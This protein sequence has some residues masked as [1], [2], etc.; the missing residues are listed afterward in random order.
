MR[1]TVYESCMH[2]FHQTIASETLYDVRFKEVCCC[3]PSSRPPARPLESFCLKD[4]CCVTVFVTV[5]NCFLFFRTQGL[6]V[7]SFVV[8]MVLRMIRG[9]VS[10]TA[11]FNVRDLCPIAHADRTF[12]PALFVAGRNDDFIRPHHSQQIHD[13]YAGDKNIVLVEGDHNSSRPSF[14]FDSV[15]IFLQNYLQVSQYFLVVFS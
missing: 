10:K 9:S 1:F 3:R 6:T 11:G 4:D 2:G 7:P 13:L 14:L 8:K 12:I 15:Y 5:Y